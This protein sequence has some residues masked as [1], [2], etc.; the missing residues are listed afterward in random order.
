MVLSYVLMNVIIQSPKQQTAI[1][2]R[3]TGV[4]GKI[5]ATNAKIS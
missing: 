5:L 2:G 3:K 1:N 4:V